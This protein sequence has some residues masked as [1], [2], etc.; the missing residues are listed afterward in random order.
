MAYTPKTDWKAADGV[1]IADLNRIE[2]G[3]KDISTKAQ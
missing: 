3:V 1:S 2:Q